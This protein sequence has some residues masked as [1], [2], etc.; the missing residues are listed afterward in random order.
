MKNKVLRWLLRHIALN[1]HS[2]MAMVWQLQKFEEADHYWVEGRRQKLDNPKCTSYD[3]YVRWVAD[4]A[5][6]HP[7]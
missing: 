4:R 2:I 7:P 6:Q 3:E 1:H 5:S